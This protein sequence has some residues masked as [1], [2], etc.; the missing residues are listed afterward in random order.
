MV[1]RCLNASQIKSW[2]ENDTEQEI[3]ES[4][5]R[6]LLGNETSGSKHLRKPAASSILT[7]SAPV[8]LLS[9]SLNSFLAGFGVY[10]GTIWIKKLDE[11]GSPS[12][13][14]NVFLVYV[15]GLVICYGV[16]A[17]SRLVSRGQVVDGRE[18]YTLLQQVNERPSNDKPESHQQQPRGAKECFK[19][20][21]STAD[22][23]SLAQALHNAAMLREESAKADRHI[24]D[25]YRE[26][27][28]QADE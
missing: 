4:P 3:A 21:S 13:S 15:V 23:Q 20:S 28:R 9:A 18:L 8:I 22:R 5:P 14:R 24:A 27:S 17:L 10:L 25:I 26:L 16:Y 2:I 1:G 19:M 7:V 6:V 11:D 12:D